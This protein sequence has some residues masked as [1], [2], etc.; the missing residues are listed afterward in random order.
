MRFSAGYGSSLISGFLGSNP[1]HGSLTSD[2]TAES[3]LDAVIVDARS[4]AD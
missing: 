2:G 3:G 4:V 1:Y